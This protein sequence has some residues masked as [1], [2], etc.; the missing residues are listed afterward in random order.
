MITVTTQSINDIASLTQENIVELNNA[1]SSIVTLPDGKT[2]N[3]VTNVS[4]FINS[5]NNT[6]NIQVVTTP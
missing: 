5:I 4:Y 3:Q 1:L 2:W 6:G